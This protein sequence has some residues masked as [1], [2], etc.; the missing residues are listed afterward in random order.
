MYAVPND[1]AE[2][3]QITPPDNTGAKRQETP[4]SDRRHFRGFLEDRRNLRHV[5]RTR[6]VFERTLEEL[7]AATDSNSAEGDEAGTGVG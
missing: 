2:H 3:C 4:A 5:M 6:S 1:G 7:A